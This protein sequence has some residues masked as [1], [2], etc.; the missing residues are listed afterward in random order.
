MAV[1][2]SPYVRSAGSRLDTTGI[3]KGIDT[4]MKNRKEAI[5]TKAN[6][7][8]NTTYSSMMSP[9]ENFTSTDVVDWDINS[10]PNMTAGQLLEQYKTNAK[11]KGQKVYNELLNAGKFDPA[12]FKRQYDSIKQEAM[13]LIEQK[14]VNYMDM[15][16][17][18]DKEMRAFIE[19]KGLNNMLVDSGNPGPMRDL[20]LP[21]EKGFFGKA[22]ENITGSQAVSLAAS[23]YFAPKVYSSLKEKG[24]NPLKPFKSIKEATPSPLSAKKSEKLANIIDK[25]PEGKRIQASLDKKSQKILNKAQEKYDKGFDEYKKASK[26]K[27]PNTSGFNKTKAGA[28]L[29][30]NILNKQ[31]QSKAS[32]LTAK[33]VVKKAID[34]HGAAK[35]MKLLGER[36]GKRKAIM[37]LAKLGISA[38]MQLAPGL[39][40][41][42]SAGLLVTDA[43]HVYSI[44]KEL[45]E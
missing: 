35:V 43:Y 22:R 41:A 9:W 10:L 32:G 11:A 14:L 12:N 18:S 20:A 26:A 38:P 2:Y 40:Q 45:A 13:P 1:D 33:N 23:A 4:F 30:K 27:K 8:S 31:I 15:K 19:K 25:S 3:Q 6:E 39:G 5:V 24:F 37:M 29:N 42:L 17:L 28:E 44:I 7:L 21:K 16:G 36:L 34:K